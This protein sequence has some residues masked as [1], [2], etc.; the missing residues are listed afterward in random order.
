MNRLLFMG[1]DFFHIVVNFCCF[2]VKHSLVLDFKPE[3]MQ[4]EEQFFE[5]PPEG[6]VN[7]QRQ[8]GG[9]YS[10]MSRA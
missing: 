2:I 4:T 10:I 3:A 9:I 8:F 5:K 1:R 7:L 6:F